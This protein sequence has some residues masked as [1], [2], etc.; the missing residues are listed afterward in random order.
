MFKYYI[1]LNG[2]EEKSAEVSHRC[3]VEPLLGEQIRKPLS[4][5]G[6]S[7]DFFFPP[8]GGFPPHLL[9]DWLKYS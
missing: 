4:A 9:N 5:C 7:G 1:G 8:E 6:W 3:G 2:L